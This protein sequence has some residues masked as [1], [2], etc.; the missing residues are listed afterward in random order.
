MQLASQLGVARQ[1]G[2]YDAAIS[3]LRERATGDAEK[4]TQAPSPR[5]RARGRPTGTTKPAPAPGPCKVTGATGSNDERNMVDV[6]QNDVADHATEFVDA[7]AKHR[8]W[9]ENKTGTV[10]KSCRFCRCLASEEDPVAAT[11]SSGGEVHF[12]V[13]WNPGGGSVCYYCARVHER[14]KYRALS[15]TQLGARLDTLE[16]VDRNCFMALRAKAIKLLA[17]GGGSGRLPRGF[18]LLDVVP[19]P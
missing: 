15:R 13:R 4:E 17:E 2:L 5:K 14:S 18:A 16:D 9:P 19:W 11:L 10:Q 3:L 1:H 7:D 8:Q 6:L 12:P